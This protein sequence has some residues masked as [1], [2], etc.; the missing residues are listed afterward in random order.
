MRRMGIADTQRVPGLGI[1]AAVMLVGAL[2]LGLLAAPLAAEAQQTGKIPRIGVLQVWSSA[3]PVVELVRQGLREVGYVEGQTIGL[4]LRWAEGKTERL[5]ALADD[6]VQRK[7]DAIMAFGDPA[8]RAAQQATRTIPIIATTDDLVGSGLVASFTRPGGN[9]TGVSILASELNIKRLELLKETLPRV[10]RVAALWDPGSGRFHLRGLEAAAQSL[11]IELRILEV[12]RPGDF[13]QA[14][15]AAKR[16]RTEALNVLASP[17]LHGNR[18]TILD[19]AAKNRLPAI[20]QWRESAEAGGLMSYGPRL[21][22]MMR[23]TAAML[24][25]I[26]KGARPA[27]LP[28]EQPTKF[29]L[30]INLKTAKALGLTIPQSVLVQ[31]DE[32]IR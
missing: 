4:E 14:F 32:V 30:V 8:I 25:K 2:A 17:F 21:S 23:D 10:S 27:D 19:L 11:G 12:G 29:E 3:D 20:Y 24:D 28:V 18:Q 6:L 5:P 22:D 16:S 1:G 26:L 9:T 31:A 15:E 13:R 7:V